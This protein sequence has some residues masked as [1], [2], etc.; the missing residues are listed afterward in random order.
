[1]INSN[2]FGLCCDA[3]KVLLPEVLPSE[4]ERYSVGDEQDKRNAAARRA[5]EDRRDAMMIE[6]AGR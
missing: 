4:R 3:C 6:R 1:M 5:L 2:R